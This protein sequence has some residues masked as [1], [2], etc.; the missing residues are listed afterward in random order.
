MLCLMRKVVVVVLC[1]MCDVAGLIV[2]LVFASACKIV[3][4]TTLTSNLP[5]RTGS[6]CSNCKISK[7]LMYCILS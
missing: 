3:R 1:C 7:E 2:S 5:N 4:M 6:T